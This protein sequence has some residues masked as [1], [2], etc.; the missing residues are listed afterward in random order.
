MAGLHTLV[1]P[2]YELLGDDEDADGH[3][4][5][6]AMKALVVRFGAGPAAATTACAAPPT[7]AH[8]GRA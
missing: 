5:L 2:L 8:H 1:D 4:A 3:P 7:P 6:L